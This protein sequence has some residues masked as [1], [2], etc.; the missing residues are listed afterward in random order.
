[1]QEIAFYGISLNPIKTVGT[2][3]IAWSVREP[4]VSKDI[5]LQ[6]CSIPNNL[7]TSVMRGSRFGYLVHLLLAVLQKKIILQIIQK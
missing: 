1:M 5:Y 2:T 7:V 6:V 4:P 3:G